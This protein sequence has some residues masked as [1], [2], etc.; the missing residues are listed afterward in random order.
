MEATIKKIIPNENKLIYPINFHWFEIVLQIILTKQQVFSGIIC[1]F[2]LWLN[3][4]VNSYGNVE[5]VG[6]LT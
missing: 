2:G 1:L 4:P 5:M 6:K 3:V